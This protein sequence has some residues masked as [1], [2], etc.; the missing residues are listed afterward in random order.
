MHTSMLGTRRAVLRF[1]SRLHRSPLPTDSQATCTWPVPS[2]DDRRPAGEVHGLRL[3]NAAMCGYARR[4]RK[5]QHVA[6]Y[7]NSLV[8][9][10]DVAGT[11]GRFENDFAPAPQKSVKRTEPELTK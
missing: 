10:S 2:A 1:T 8:P 7:G 3:S 4:V 9:L 11:T 6:S 5:V